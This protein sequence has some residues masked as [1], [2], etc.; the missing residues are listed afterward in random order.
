LIF[1]AWAPLK[2]GQKGGGGGMKKVWLC[3]M[4]VALKTDP[5]KLQYCS[6]QFCFYFCCCRAG[7]SHRFIPCCK[8]LVPVR[9]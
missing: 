3:K 8:A 1:S 4:G 2:T 6:N 7:S 5:H 9:G